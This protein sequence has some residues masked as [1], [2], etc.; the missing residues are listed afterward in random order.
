[1]T[2]KGQEP[3]TEGACKQIREDRVDQGPAASSRS[4]TSVYD[5]YNE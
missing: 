3:Y 2:G 1:L 5:L 4:T